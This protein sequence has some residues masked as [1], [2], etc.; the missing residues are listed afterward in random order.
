MYEPYTTTCG[1]TYCYAVGF[2][3][4]RLTSNLLTQSVFLQIISAESGSDMS[5]MS[6]QA[7]QPT[8]ARICTPRDDQRLH[9]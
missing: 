2:S 7:E 1:H 5:G 4:S 3:D 8:G 6:R 9:R